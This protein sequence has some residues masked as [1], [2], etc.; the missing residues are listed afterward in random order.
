MARMPAL[1]SN[2][3]ILKFKLNNQPVATVT[4]LTSQHKQGMARATVS[5][6]HHKQG[7]GGKSIMA[8]SHNSIVAALAAK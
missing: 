4:V 1:A 7:M 3:I 5:K 8:Q 2:R 6:N